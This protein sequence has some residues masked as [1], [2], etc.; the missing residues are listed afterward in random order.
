MTVLLA[1][2]NLEDATPSNRTTFIKFYGGATS[3]TARLAQPDADGG[4]IIAGK[5]ARPGAIV[6]A[7]GQILDTDIV[8]IKTDERGNKVWET[9]VD[10]GS[11]SALKIVADGYLIIGKGIEINRDA[12][13]VSEQ[14]NTT[15][16]LIKMDFSGKI[17]SDIQKDSSITRIT[18]VDTITQKV[19][20]QGYAVNLTQDGNIITL[21]SYK[22][23][24][25]QEKSVT[26]SLNS[27]LQPIW[28]KVYDLRNFDY[29]NAPSIHET[30]GKNLLWASTA[31]NTISLS[32][33][34]SYLSIAYVVPNST[35][36]NNSLFG[37]NDSR[38]YTASD[39]QPGATGYGVVG[40]YAEPNGTAA[41]LYFVQVDPAGNVLAGTEHYFDA[42][43]LLTG[44][45]SASE[46]SG[47]AITS[48]N[49][50]G[51]VLAGTIETTAKVGN[52]DRDIVLIKIDAFGN[53]IWTRLFGGASDE[54]VGSVKELADGTLLISGTASLG[55]IS[56]MFIMKTD[57]DGELKD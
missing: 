5:V 33:S 49:T 32:T 12:S 43:S 41:D 6:E 35:F 56:S 53:V 10:M 48:T 9:L 34:K 51:Y 8:V 23:P 47:D 52:G 19:D 20:F 26:T 14:V 21:T 45:A 37:E 28:S 4:F 25:G 2:T 42:E 46:D 13:Q 31:Y 55:N 27:S 40:T 57:K 38:N 3:Y 39:I 36:D 50:G 7:D 44:E 30:T 24:G 16:R 22:V 18:Q 1:C 54:T 15:A 17:L 29:V 11:A